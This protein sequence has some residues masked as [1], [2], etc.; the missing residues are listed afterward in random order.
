MMKKQ[1]TVDY[2]CKCPFYASNDRWRIF[3]E[4]V[5]PGSSL[6]VS[7]KDERRKKHYEE[8]YCKE[9]YK[10]CLVARMLYEKNGGMV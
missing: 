9:H 8:N 7:F 5:C 6:Q 3:C 10:E 4:G 1:R 2:N